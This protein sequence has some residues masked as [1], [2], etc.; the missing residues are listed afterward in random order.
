MDRSACRLNNNGS[1]K[2]TEASLPPLR[3]IHMVP[4]G[5][6]GPALALG[7]LG[8]NKDRTGGGQ[9]VLEGWGGVEVCYNRGT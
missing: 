7:S 2:L 6:R 4:K 1:V 9:L 3:P 8:Q 5:A